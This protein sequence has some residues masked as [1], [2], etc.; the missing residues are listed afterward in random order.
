MFDPHLLRIFHCSNYSHF[1]FWLWTINFV[2]ISKQNPYQGCCIELCLGFKWAPFTIGHIELFIL[3]LYSNWIECYRWQT[4][5]D[6]QNVKVPEFARLE[7][8]KATHSVFVKWE[9][10]KPVGLSER[11]WMREMREST[12]KRWGYLLLSSKGGKERNIEGEKLA[13]RDTSHQQM[14]KRDLKC[15]LYSRA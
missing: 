12:S 5:H 2:R 1:R 11:K 6:A 9:E 4:I 13:W 10:W 14:N 3:P 8:Q 7:N 15:F